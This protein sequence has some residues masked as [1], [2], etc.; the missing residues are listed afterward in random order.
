MNHST[1]IVSK[2]DINE[3]SLVEVSNRVAEL[4]VDNVHEFIE[5]H[6]QSY[7]LQLQINNSSNIAD[8]NVCN[9]VN[10]KYTNTVLQIKKDDKSV[11]HKKRNW[12]GQNEEMLL[13][14]TGNKKFKLDRTYIQQKSFSMKNNFLFN[15]NNSNSF[16]KCDNVNVTDNNMLQNTDNH[17]TLNSNNDTNSNTS[18]KIQIIQESMKA[19]FDTKKDVSNSSYTI[20]DLDNEKNESIPTKEYSTNTENIDEDNLNEDRISACSIQ[21]NDQKQVE[22][23]TQGDSSDDDCIS[24]YAETFTS[25]DETFILNNETKAMTDCKMIEK[26]QNTFGTNIRHNILKCTKTFDTIAEP[27]ISINKEFSN[28]EGIIKYDNIQTSHIS[29]T[30]ILLAN[31]KTITSI[32]SVSVNNN[33]DSLLNSNCNA[34]NANIVSNDKTVIQHIEKI[35]LWKYKIYIKGYCYG[36]IK[37]GLCLKKKCYYEHDLQKLID[38]IIYEYKQHL[39]DIIDYLW[40]L[41]HIYFV[42][43]LYIRIVEELDITSIM[44][45]YEK[46]YLQK[47]VNLQVI[48]ATIRA[49]LNKGMNPS[50]VVNN[51]CKTLTCNDKL[52]PYYILISIKQRIKSD[53][54]WNTLRTLIKFIKPDKEIIETILNDCII[55]RRNIQDVYVNLIKKLHTNEIYQLDTN[56]ISSFNNLLQ[57]EYQNCYDEMSPR[58]VDN[59]ESFYNKSY[60]LHSISNLS[61]PHSLYRNRFRN[62]YLMLNNLEEKLLHEDYDYVINMLNIYQE[63]D[64]N[65]SLYSRCCFRIFCAEIKHSEYH[66]SKIIKRAVQT[67]AINEVC[68][69]LLDVAIYILTRLVVDEIWIQAYKLLKT[70]Q[71]CNVHYDAAFV[72]LSAEIYLANNQAITAFML[73]KQSNIISTNRK[74]WNVISNSEDY[75]LRTK[76]INIL[77]DALCEKSSEYVFFM[78]QFLIKDQ[79]NSFEPINLACYVDKLML[80]FLTKKET[81]L[82]VKM[83]YMIIEYNF[84]FANNVTCRAAIATLVHSNMILA[85][86]LYQ[87][88][89]GLGIYRTIEISSFIQILINADW[90]EEEIY[91]MFLG[92]FRRLAMNVGHSIDRFNSTQLSI[93]IIFEDI[94]TEANLYHEKS[95]DQE[96][97]QINISKQLVRQVLRTRFDPS[98]T[99]IGK[100][101]DTIMQLNIMSVIDY[102]KFVL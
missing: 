55:N 17:I 6:E 100:I 79:A 99:M 12:F 52:T 83:G 57:H 29:S 35:Q 44:N 26:D 43:I 54:Y 37:N 20:F 74:N 50:H 2:V 78:F 33:K 101:N 62:L 31:S 38:K 76:I 18:Y 84:T 48:S 32:D 75:Y 68:K 40:S 92:F 82:I 66:I 25:R 8:I 39:T 42:E 69:I 61:K 23:R 49:F 51:L 28:S 58:S 91:L 14:K 63:T 1:D 34:Y 36:M 3:S 80:K 86:R 81:E 13:N 95:Y 98:L 11:S 9:S 90:V 88:A 87:Y 96:K 56:L 53:E 89:S 22:N 85:E 47:K 4:T 24:L 16:S 77:L 71:I 21:L 102:L 27:D 73:L 65:Q 97:K 45:I 10:D 64:D 41:R 59:N 5:N 70:L 72:I 30:E 94:P 7:L 67:G 46:F 60:T 19:G 15:N 93:Y